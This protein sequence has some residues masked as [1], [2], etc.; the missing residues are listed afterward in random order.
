[1]REHEPT[2]FIV[3]DDD[4]V[5]RGLARLLRSAGYRVETFASAREYLAHGDRE[6]AGCLVLDVRMPG[7]SG[8]ELHDLLL[9]AGRDIPVVFI[10]GH[11]DMSMAVRATKSGTDFLLKPV[12]GLTLLNAV[13]Q[14]IG[15]AR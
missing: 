12:D 3:D 13:Q 6:A 14:A 10:T 5:R 9:E 1:V 7:Q 11:G 2:V 15:Q 4:S 8:L